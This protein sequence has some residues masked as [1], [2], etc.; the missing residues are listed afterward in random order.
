[1]SDYQIT[2]L[3]QI[4]WVIPYL[5]FVST[6]YWFLSYSFLK[7]AHGILIILAFVYALVVCEY[8]EFGPPL[9]VYVPMYIFL[10][11]GLASV[12]FSFKAFNGKSWV[13]IIHGFSLLSAF[14]IW[15]VGS[16]AISHD[17]I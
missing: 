10:I 16:M 3:M 8:T 9:K 4:W 17:W 15:L 5:F 12:A 13:H 1:M 2:T 11:A 6:L 14:L 7:S